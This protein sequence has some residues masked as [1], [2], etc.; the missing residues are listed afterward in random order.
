VKPFPNGRRDIWRCRLLRSDGTLEGRTSLSRSGFR[1]DA[2]DQGAHAV[3]ALRREMLLEAQRAEGAQGVDGENLLRRSIGQKRN[4]DRN[5]S[6]HKVRV[7]VAAIMQ[8]RLAVGAPP[9]LALQPHLTDAAPHLIG[10]VVRRLAQRLERMTEFDDIAIAV[11]PIVKEGEI[12]ADGGEISQASLDLMLRTDDI[13]NSLERPKARA[14]STRGLGQSAAPGPI[15]RA[16]V[17]SG[18][19]PR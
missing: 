15:F 9:R 17:F 6:A 10:L 3:R 12:V 19:R 2:I 18:C 1:A 13:Y 16:Q 4:R 5:Q 11:L 14:S 8:D 7:A